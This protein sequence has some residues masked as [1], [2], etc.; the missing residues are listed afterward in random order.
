MAVTKI[1][2][3][4]LPHTNLLDMAGAAQVFFEAKEQGIDLEIGYC[5]FEKNI[6]SS[7]SLPLGRIQN[8]STQKMKTGDYI[9]IVSADIK[10][11]MSGDMRPD[12]SL[13]KWITDAYKNGVNICSVCNGAFLLGQT[14]LLN[15]RN[16]TTHWKRTKELKEKFPAANVMEN[17]LFMEDAGIFTS[18][19]ASSGIDIAL[20][21]ISKLR[22]DYFSYQISRELV[23]YNRRSGG[24]VQ[25][26]IFLS[27]RNHMHAGIHKVQDWLQ[28]NLDRK[29]SLEL[30]ADIAFMSSRNLTRIFK[31]ETGITINEFVTLLRK[32]RIRE[33]V[34]NPDISRQQ[35]ARLCG[36]KSQKQVSRLLKA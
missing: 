4:V 36:F 34:K 8:F 7:A 20:H 33:L 18:A 9:F 35:I 5:S 24:H 16:C 3:L 19:G 30:L 26:S 28:E 13:L 17:I 15:G 22:G 25:Q 11:I 6:I 21:I 2:F 23:I 14:G 32:E 27:F 12:K 10:Y 1:V 31:K 29:I